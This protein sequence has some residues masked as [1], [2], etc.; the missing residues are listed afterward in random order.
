MVTALSMSDAQFMLTGVTGET[1]GTQRITLKKQTQATAMILRGIPNLPRLKGPFG[2]LV[3][4]QISL[5]KRGRP[6]EILIQMTAV[7][8]IACQ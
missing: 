1:E 5:H 2:M 3:R 8:M 4:T 6:Y 7:L